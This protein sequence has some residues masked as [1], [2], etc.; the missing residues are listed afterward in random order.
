MS[1][2]ITIQPASELQYLQILVLAKYMAL[3]LSEVHRRQ[4]VVALEGKKIIGFIRVKNKIDVIELAT[5]GVVKGYRGQGVGRMLINYCKSKYDHLHL[6]TCMPKH[7]EKQGFIR[8]F[9]V[10]DVLQSKYNNTALWAGYGDPVVLVFQKENE[11]N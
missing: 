11:V 2:E 4:F 1:F 6:I 8:V 9:A 7:F 10:P 5:M 3:D